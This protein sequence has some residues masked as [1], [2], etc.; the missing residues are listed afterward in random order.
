MTTRAKS[1][2]YTTGVRWEAE[3]L[4]TLACQ[5]RPDIKISSPPEFKGQDGLW[6][7]ETLYVGSIESCLFLT[8]VALAKAKKLDFLGYES[9]AVGTLEQLYGKF[10]VS[11]VVVKPKVTVKTAEDAKV[12][13]DV[14]GT[15]HDQCFISNSV[16]SEVVVEP[17]VKVQS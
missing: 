15:M 2:S 9:Q 13:Q 11:K 10:V 3:L 7:P 16:E 14:L 4:G 1:F 6:T 17:E 8:F 12:A 5:G